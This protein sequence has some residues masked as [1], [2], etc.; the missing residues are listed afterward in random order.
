VSPGGHVGHRDN[1]AIVAEE[2]RPVK[3]RRAA[4]TRPDCE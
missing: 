2:Q 4:R 1:L 3:G